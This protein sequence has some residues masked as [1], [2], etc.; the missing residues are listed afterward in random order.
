M[1]SCLSE[2]CLDYKKKFVQEINIEK[3][4]L[5]RERSFYTKE[6]AITDHKC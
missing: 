5:I 2:L 6:N 4:H 3:G 1:N